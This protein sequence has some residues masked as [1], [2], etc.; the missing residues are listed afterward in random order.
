MKGGVTMSKSNEK[1]SAVYMSTAD[2]I[3][4]RT[5]MLVMQA[6]KANESI[7]NAANRASQ[8]GKKVQDQN[9]S[10]LHALGK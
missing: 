9:N 8:V 4:A 7:T 10:I 1:D 2:A 5:Q 6:T 3:T